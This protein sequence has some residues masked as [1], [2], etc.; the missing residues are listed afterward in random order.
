MVWGRSVCLYMF[1]G[2]ALVGRG[3]YQQRDL[4]INSQPMSLIWVV[5]DVFSCQPRISHDPYDTWHKQQ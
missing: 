4:L 2:L 3:R 1:L 5:I